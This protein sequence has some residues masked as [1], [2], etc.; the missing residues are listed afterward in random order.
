MV[1]DSDLGDLI[2]EFCRRGRRLIGTIDILG[3]KKMVIVGKFL[4]Y[5]VKTELPENNSSS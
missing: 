1:S 3:F 4:K 2:S 5:F